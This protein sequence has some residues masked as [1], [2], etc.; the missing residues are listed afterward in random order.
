MTIPPS[1]KQLSVRT[2]NEY[3][4]VKGVFVPQTTTT[5]ATA[6]LPVANP[7]MLLGVDAL[8]F[9][10]PATGTFSFTFPNLPVR[11][12]TANPVSSVPFG[13]QSPL[14]IPQG[15]LMLFNLSLMNAPT[16][17]RFSGYAVMPGNPPGPSASIFVPAPFHGPGSYS[18]F[19]VNITGTAGQS[20]TIFAEVFIQRG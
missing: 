6:S 15:S 10:L 3:N 9:V 13:S 18:V 12:N 5:Q 17:V 16:W 1:P 20:G 14:V 11:T 7:P 2:V 4:A 19:G 8:N